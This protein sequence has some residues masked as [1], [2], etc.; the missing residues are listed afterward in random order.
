MSGVSL[1]HLPA[2]RQELCEDSCGRKPCIFDEAEDQV[3]F[4]GKQDSGSLKTKVASSIVAN[5]SIQLLQVFLN[6]SQYTDGKIMWLTLM[7]LAFVV[8]A[9]M[10]GFLERL[11]SKGKYDDKGV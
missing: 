3:R 10:L 6:S 1:R 8:S 2:G 11:M 4:L 5:S 7:H 9:V